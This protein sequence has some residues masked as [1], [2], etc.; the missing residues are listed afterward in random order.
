[1]PL[2]GSFP[3]FLSGLAITL[4]MATSCRSQNDSAWRLRQNDSRE[5]ST[6]HRI[7]SRPPTPFGSSTLGGHGNA[8]YPMNREEASLI[9]ILS[10]D[11]NN[12]HFVTPHLQASL[13]LS[14]VLGQRRVFGRFETT[15]VNARSSWRTSSSPLIRSSHG[16]SGG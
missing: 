4:V 16:S 5:L 1:M 12:T 11:L 3:I 15:D 7:S 14:L 13:G 2:N 9:Y 10:R 8:P 6:T